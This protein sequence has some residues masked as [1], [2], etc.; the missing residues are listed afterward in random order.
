MGVFVNVL[1]PLVFFLLTFWFGDD[2]R[3]GE[4]QPTTSPGELQTSDNGIEGDP[5]ADDMR[6][7]SDFTD[8]S[9]E[10]HDSQS[11]VQ[12][13]LHGYLESRNRLRTTDSEFISTRQ[14]LWLEG[15]GGYGAVGALGAQPPLR[16]F[17]SGAVDVDPMAADL[18]DDHDTARIY[19][20][21]AFLTVDRPGYNAVVGRKIHRIGTGDG[22]NPMD[23]INPLD[24]RD[25][26]ATGS[27]DARL[28]VLLGLATIN[29]PV[30]G[31]FQ[32]ANLDMIVVPLA[33]VNELNSPGSAWEGPGLRELRAGHD[34]GALYP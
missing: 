21:E 11:E 13:D 12:L 30:W 19:L 20:E 8:A 10:E 28:P 7:S 5:F 29:L 6:F 26:F 18:S 17:V 24:Y 3:A 9:E 25:P 1:V 32:E 4:P 16:G 31:S 15:Q 23:L 14:R 33:Q 27:S 22:I 34:E 2:I